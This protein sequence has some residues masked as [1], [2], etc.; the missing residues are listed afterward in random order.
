MAAKPYEIVVQ[1]PVAPGLLMDLLSDYPSIAVQSVLTGRVRDQAEL[2]GL[3]R[4]LHDLG[5]EIVA[6]RQLLAARAESPAASQTDD[7]V[8]VGGSFPTART[9]GHP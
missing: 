7:V 2:Q 3:L 9:E 1:G 4:R 6:F 8:V 5:I